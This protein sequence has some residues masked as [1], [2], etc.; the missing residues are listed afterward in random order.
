ML[1]LT[2]LNKLDEAKDTN[3]FVQDNI[4]D[5]NYYS[6][7]LKSF[8]FN[9][10]QRKDVHNKTAMNKYNVDA[11]DKF[12]KVN[13][14]WKIFVEY[15][16]SQDFI[17]FLNVNFSASNRGQ[18]YLSSHLTVGYEFSI[19]GDGAQ[20]VPHKD[21]YGKLFSFVFYF[22]P[23]GWNKKNSY[24]GTQF[25]EPKNRLLNKKIFNG[26]SNF[27]S[28]NCVAEVTPSP[29]RLLIFEPNNTSW[30]GVEPISTDDSFGRP[31]FIVTIHRKT[32]HLE[33]LYEKCSFI[34]S[35]IQ[36][37]LFN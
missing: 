27:E 37:Y 28:M 3:V 16:L 36:K 32:T 22:V 19:L 11:V 4:L 23:E 18:H 33:N 8:P 2:K 1:K 25:Y 9:E 26:G 12:L 29:N 24:G 21:K 7:L 6:I 30:H 20:V 5:S 35:R 15:F 14:D 10:M 31:A 17:N 13:K 34:T